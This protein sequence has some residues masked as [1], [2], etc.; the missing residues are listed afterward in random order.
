MLLIVKFN[1]RKTHHQL[2]KAGYT[3]RRYGDYIKKEVNGRWHIKPVEYGVYDIHF[4]LYVG[5][6]HYA[7]SMPLATKEEIK[8]ILS[9][10]RRTQ[11]KLRPDQ[12][13][14]MKQLVKDFSNHKL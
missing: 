12:I 10:S 9:C 3:H 14:D 4:D 11:F 2:I 6:T 7:P 1:K 13:E 8:R 5:K